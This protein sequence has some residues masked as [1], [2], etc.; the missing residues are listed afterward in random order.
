LR[1]A[2]VSVISNIVEGRGKATDKD[3]L[4]FLY[5]AKGSLNECQCQIEIA[6]A[7]EFITTEQSDFIINKLNEVGYLLYKLMSS[8]EKPSEPSRLS[9]PS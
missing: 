8:L 3:F 6:L 9:K 2:S 4:R 5:I 1:R 7:L